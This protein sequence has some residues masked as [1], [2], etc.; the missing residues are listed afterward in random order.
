LVVGSRYL[1]Q[2]GPP[3]IGL[4]NATPVL[5]MLLN[6]LTRFSGRSE[7]VTGC[8]D[9]MLI[10]QI[11]KTDRTTNS[12]I[13]FFIRFYSILTEVNVSKNLRKGLLT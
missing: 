13:F 12:T 3:D 9:V 11:A 7:K 4:A 1:R 2:P 5:K 10:A 6:K 8:I